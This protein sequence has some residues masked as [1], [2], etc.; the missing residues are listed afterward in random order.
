MYYS[1][2]CTSV[3]CTVY[4]VQCTV[5]RPYNRTAQYFIVVVINICSQFVIHSGGAAACRS[6]AETAAPSTIRI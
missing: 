5:Q 3:Q 4:S 2:Q 6:T 1:V